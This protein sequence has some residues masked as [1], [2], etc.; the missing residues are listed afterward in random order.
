M[1]RTDISDHLIHFTK[2]DSPEDAFSTLKAIINE[3]IL[4]GGSGNIKG[5][6]TCVCFSEA[7]IDSLV[8]GLINADCYSKYSR[9]GVMVDKIWLFQQGGRPVI[10]QTDD[11]FEL[12][13]EANRW[14]HVRYE[15]HKEV[16]ID[17]S[18]ER[19]WRIKCTQLDIHP[20][21]ASIIVPDSDWGTRL[22]YD[23]E[24]E[25]QWRIEEYSLIFDEDFAQN[26]YEPFTWNV[27]PLRLKT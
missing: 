5:G 15:P 19:E 4:V 2:G 20:G 23:H 11:E 13:Q 25:Q 12:L 6:Y 18:W 9:F 1:N 8:H 7:P 26:F 24:H 16:P 27:F 22:F 3:R 21:V 10:Y 17:F 14:R